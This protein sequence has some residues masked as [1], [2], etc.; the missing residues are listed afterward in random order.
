MQQR[1]VN[2]A[3]LLL[4]EQAQPLRAC[5]PHTAPCVMPHGIAAAPL[6]SLLAARR[7]TRPEPAPAS[8]ADSAI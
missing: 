3:W 6:S 8:G 4:F 1:R 2:V 7:A 5:G